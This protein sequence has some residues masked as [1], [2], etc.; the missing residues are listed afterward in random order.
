LNHLLFLVS[1]GGGN[2]KFFHTAIAQK[3]LQNMQISALS[4]RECGAISYAKRWEIDHHVIEYSRKN[5]HQLQQEII[6]RSPSLVITNWH[7]IIDPNTVQLNAGRLINLH[8]SLLPAFGGL[9]GIEPLRKAYEKKC[10]FIGPSCHLVDEGVDTGEILA[11]AVFSTNRPFEDAVGK[12]FRAGCLT[13]LNAI[14]M[15]LGASNDVSEEFDGL[16]FSP[17]LCF[18]ASIYDEKFWEDVSQ[19]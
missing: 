14:H 11:Q 13:L 7:K 5:P 9:I 2:L 17:P 15:K 19:A 3:K 16:R 4:D 18:D 12:M 6:R 8:Y 1:G 10:R